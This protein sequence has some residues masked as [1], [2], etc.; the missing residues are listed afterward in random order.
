MRLRAHAG[1]TLLVGLGIAAGAGVLA[2]T[3][4]GAK[5][6]QD[7]AVQQALAALQPSD[8]SV[9][10]VWSGVPGQS[11]LPLSGLDRVARRSLRLVSAD[12]PTRVIV[13]RQA[14]WGGAFVNL[15]AVDGLARWIVLRSGRLPRPCTREDCE[16]VQIGGA[17]VAPKL[18]FLHVVGQAALKP[19]A[20][21][22]SYFGATVGK[23]PPILLADGVR[24]LAA[25]PLPDAVTIARTYGWVVPLAPRSVHEWQLAAIAGRLDAAENRLQS[26]SDIFSLS[27]PTDTFDSVRASTRV[28]GQRLLVLGGDAAVLLL[29]FAVLA[30]ARLRREQE[31][32]RRRLTW[33]GA[34]RAQVVLVAAVEVAGL[35]LVAGAIGFG[36][37]AGAGALLA[38]HLGSPASPILAHSLLTWGALGA[39][40]ALA[41][42]TTAVLLAALVVPPLAF[43]GLR[44]TIAD[45]AA[46]GALGAVLLA[47]ARGKADASSLTAG[48]GTGVVLLLLPALVLFVLAVAAA[49]LLTPLL[50]GLEWAGRRGRPS[51]RAALLSLARAPGQVVLSVAF[52]V[53]SVG[54]ALFAV[55][56]RA[57]LVNGEAEQARYAVPA[58]YVLQEDL[59]KLV[60]VQQVGGLS[61]LGRA[62]PV[63][64]DSGYVTGNGGRGFTLLALPPAA[65]AG[66]DGWRSDFSSQ[67]P[68]VLARLLRPTVTPE[69]RGFA[70]A[71]GARRFTLPLEITGD[72]LGITLVVLDR[73][74]DFSDLSFGELGPG[75]HAPTVAVPPAARGGR[76][77]AV[78]LSFPL[79]AAFAANH[80][81]SGTSLA[82]ND[83]ATGTIRLGGRFAAW[84]GHGGVHAA[85]GGTFRYLLNRAAD[86]ILRPHEPLEG[87][88]VPV[89]AT[90]GVGRVGDTVPLN[91]G[92]TVIPGEIV[93]TTRYVPSV[94]GDAVVADL[95]TWLEA[96][97]T[98][99]PGS[100]APEEVWLHPK[101]GAAARLAQPPYDSLVVTS[102]RATAAALRADPLARGS[103]TLLLATA[104]VALALAAVG[105]VLTVVGDL[106]DEGG[107]LLDLSALGMPPAALRRHVL[108]RAG[109]VAAVG[110]GLGVAAGAIVGGLVVSV[111]TVTAGAADA[112]PP[113]ALVFDWPVVLAALAAV[114]VVAAVPSLVVLRRLR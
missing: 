8:R 61:A 13:F 97:N 19:G 107:V 82:V 44:L 81:D 102:Q 53:V 101:P 90:P 38:R 11:D 79:Y 109:I 24:G 54:V 9:Q 18:P 40:A 17:P 84:E 28:A 73:R 74:G 35:T 42:V 105:I 64:R 45:V 14:T 23:R 68:A 98:A 48:G 55:A 57:T 29:G 99:D 67:S 88:A 26:I 32:V 111:V 58:P 33:L 104:L 63:V 72:K 75:R 96:A 93:A 10:A 70:L 86:S 56:Y 100:T 21:F 71:V 20:P 31:A 114:L 76:V 106:E 6:V 110:I 25:T 113:L 95:G 112:L 52:F 59:A 37:G 41:V 62:A 39:G 78:R 43:G 65:L 51:L 46:L 12:A 27:A 34:T 47:L 108:I 49:R 89:V 2:A 30:A 22:R 3:L 36:A 103:V 1:R 83:S 69:L 16:L 80:R 5:A 91:V 50:R 15:G 87:D 60:T 85:G 77:V 7:R 4:V 66:I 92:G 94:S